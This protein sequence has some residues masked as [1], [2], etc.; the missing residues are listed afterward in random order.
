[1]EYYFIGSERMFCKRRGLEVG[2]DHDSTFIKGSFKV[3]ET[4]PHWAFTTSFIFSI[5]PEGSLCNR[6]TLQSSW[7]T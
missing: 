7:V 6:R 3:S 2:K 4:L 5:S 1:M